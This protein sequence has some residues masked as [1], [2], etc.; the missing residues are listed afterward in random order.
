MDAGNRDIDQ[1]GDAHPG[2]TAPA[3]RARDGIVEAGFGAPHDERAA[4][5]IDN[6]HRGLRPHGGIAGASDDLFSLEASRHVL[7]P[8]PVSWGRL[9]IAL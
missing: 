3:C 2:V 4:G 5:P 1:V 8:F 9:A 6:V 7:V